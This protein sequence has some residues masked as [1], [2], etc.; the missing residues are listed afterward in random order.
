MGGQF[1]EKIVKLWGGVVFV[2]GGKR[3]EREKKKKRGKRS[4]HTRKKNKEKKNTQTKTQ[5]RK[6]GGGRMKGGLKVDQQNIACSK[7]QGS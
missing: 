1:R 4:A 3:M 2:F 6:K 7:I 5:K